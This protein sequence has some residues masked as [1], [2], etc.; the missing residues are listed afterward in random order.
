MNA[1]KTAGF[2]MLSFILMSTLAAAAGNAERGKALFKDPK[3]GGGTAGISC[4]SCHP[5]GQ[6]LEK[7][8]DRNTKDLEKTV[9]ACVE[10]ALKGKEIDPQ[11][12][13]MADL[14]AYIQSLKGKTP[15]A[16]APKK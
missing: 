10:K 15:A 8:S 12:A 13:E 2:V 14:V 1:L 11:S 5:D 3:L 7:A 9:N 16:G 4:N 6:G